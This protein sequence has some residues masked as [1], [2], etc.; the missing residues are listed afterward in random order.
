VESVI[1]AVVVSVLYSGHDADARLDSLHNTLEEAQAR[2]DELTSLDEYG[3]EA[4][5][6]VEFSNVEGEV[7]VRS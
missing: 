7:I 1:K 3:D 5:F 4:H 2:V 6:V